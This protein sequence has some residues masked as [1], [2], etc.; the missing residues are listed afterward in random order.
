MC[1]HSLDPHQLQLHPDVV[2]N[3]GQSVTRN[4][5]VVDYEPINVTGLIVSSDNSVNGSYAKVGDEIRLT[6]TPDAILKM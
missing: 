4:V 3:P 5:T 2:G 6:F 1:Q